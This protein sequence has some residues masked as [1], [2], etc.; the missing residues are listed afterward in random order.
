VPAKQ[1][2][3]AFEDTSVPTGRS[4]SQIRDMLKAAGALGVEIGEDYERGAIQVRFGWELENGRKIAVRLNAFPLEASVRPKITE[5]Q[6]DRQAWRGL[7]WYLKAM[8]DAATF[9]L[10]TFEDV[11]LSF[12]EAAPHGPTVG[13]VVVNQLERFGRLEVQAQLEPAT[14]VEG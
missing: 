1:R 13:E 9:G 7:H 3:T 5:E 4:Q 10:L 12:M 11:F 2:R 8:I 14:V 6:R